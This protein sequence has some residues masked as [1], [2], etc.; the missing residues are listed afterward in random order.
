MADY[1]QAT[2]PE[3]LGRFFIERANA[4]DVGGLL[5]LYEADAV[6]AAASG[7]VARGADAIRQVL[8]K[9]VAEMAAHGMTFSGEPSPALRRG[10]LA[11]TS[12]RFSV[13]FVGSDGQPAT[14]GGVTAE[15]AR[16]QT[17]STW[18]FAID[19]PDIAK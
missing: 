16:R 3:H 4:G 19:Q 10:G 2:E 11:L 14:R 9:M 13:N 5:T 6:L 12:T 8:E 1:A 17:D 18:R 15:V 7:E